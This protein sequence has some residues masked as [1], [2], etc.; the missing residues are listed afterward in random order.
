MLVNI[1]PHLIEISFRCSQ[2]I[3][4]KISVYIC[5]E[6][7]MDKNL[8]IYSSIMLILGSRIFC[9]WNVIQYLKGNFIYP[10]QSSLHL[11]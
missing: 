5:D 6:Y 8:N 10:M 3:D 11:M 9:R 2:C 4:I 7:L 1:G